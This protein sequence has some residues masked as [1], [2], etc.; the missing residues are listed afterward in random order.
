MQNPSVELQRNYE[1]K[2][3]RE[4]YLLHCT[5]LFCVWLFC[6]IAFYNLPPPPPP[7][8]PKKAT[9][10][11]QSF[12]FGWTVLVTQRRQLFLEIQDHRE[13]FWE[14]GLLWGSKNQ[15]QLGLAQA[16]GFGVPVVH[17]H[18]KTPKVPPPPLP[19]LNG[20]SCISK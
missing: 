15:P 16:M 17:P 1:A 10:N 11:S 8:P 3:I 13:G 12:C 20:H 5:T 19:Q 6:C 7:P 18:P 14:F 2:L 4:Q 9:Y